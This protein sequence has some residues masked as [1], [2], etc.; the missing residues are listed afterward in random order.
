MIKINLLPFR[1]A[2]KK[3][4]IRRQISIF[5]L[6]ILFSGLL[7]FWYS[8]HMNNQI[9]LVQEETNRVNQQISKYKERATRVK[10]IKKDLKILN[11]KLDVVSSLKMQQDKQL[12]LF[13]TLTGLIVPDRMW[14]ESLNT[15]ANTLKMK[16]IAF[17]NQTIADFMENLEASPLF[18]KIDLK[19]AKLKSFK[20]NNMLKSFELLCYKKIVVPDNKKKTKQGKK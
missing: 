7:L 1:L 3:E 4:N 10:K 11:E 9:Q 17:D 15:N 20:G 6:L 13:D 16:G 2:R 18:G 5:F 14:I 19:T 12:I 8:L